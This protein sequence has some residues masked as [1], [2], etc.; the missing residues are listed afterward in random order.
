MS[1]GSVVAT[2]V[3]SALVYLA[4][5]IVVFAEMSETGIE[6]IGTFEAV[7]YGLLW[8]PL[9]VARLVRA[10][11]TVI[12]REIKYLFVGDRRNKRRPHAIVENKINRIRL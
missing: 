9:A 6:T 11:I 12:C 8:L 3:M 7:A 1:P 5:G 2:G 10:I 4:I